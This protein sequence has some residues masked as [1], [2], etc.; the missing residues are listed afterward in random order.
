MH[1][2]YLPPATKAELLKRAAI[3]NPEIV[4]ATS[5]LAARSTSTYADEKGVERILYHNTVILTFMPSGVV[6]IDTGEHNAAS[7]RSRLNQFGRGLRFHTRQA[8]LRRNVRPF[9]RR[10]LR[11]KLGLA[12]S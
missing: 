6:L 7:T 10:F 5:K 4:I 12:V 11:S 1:T 9:L 2:A 8:T 3:L